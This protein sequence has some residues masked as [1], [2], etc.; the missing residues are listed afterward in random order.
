MIGSAIGAM[1]FTDL[2][3]KIAAMP[4]ASPENRRYRNAEFIFGFLVDR[5][6][7]FG[8]RDW[9]GLDA[10]VKAAFMDGLA[11]LESDDAPGGRS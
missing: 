2:I 3:A 10:S 11:F 8:C 1:D 5:G 9:D 4:P 6:A 7:W